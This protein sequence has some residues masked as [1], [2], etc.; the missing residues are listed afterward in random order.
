MGDTKCSGRRCFATACVIGALA[1]LYAPAALSQT[2]TSGDIAGLVKKDASVAVVP[3]AMVTIKY[4]VK[5]FDRSRGGL[6]YMF[7]S[8]IRP[9]LLA[10]PWRSSRHSN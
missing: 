2:L 3:S 6:P 8:E 9:A 7:R 5:T 1:V 10:E 4:T